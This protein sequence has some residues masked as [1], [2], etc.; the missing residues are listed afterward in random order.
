M[1]KQYQLVLDDICDKLE[2]N[3]G[4]DCY[5]SDL[6]HYLCNED[7]FI[8]GTYKAKKFLGDDAFEAIEMI[9][10]YEQSNFG[11]VSTD[12]SD[13]EKVVN[14]FAYI[15]GEYILSES[16]HLTNRYNSKLDEDDLKTIYSEICGINATK[17]YN[18]AA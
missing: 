13:P 18:E 2:D 15:V 1:I 10:N 11:Q 17:L 7:Y 6:H 12:L 9:K 4:L 16:D 3:V 8:I 14:M 5:A